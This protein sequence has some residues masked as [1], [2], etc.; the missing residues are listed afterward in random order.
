MSSMEEAIFVLGVDLFLVNVFLQG[1][2]FVIHW[3]EEQDLEWE[4]C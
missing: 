2:K 3:E 4:L 1:F